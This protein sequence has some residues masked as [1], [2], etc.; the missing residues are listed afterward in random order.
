MDAA[1]IASKS[2]IGCG[3]FGTSTS[4]PTRAYK[5]LET[6]TNEESQAQA[7]LELLELEG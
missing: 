7:I 2:Q 4:L 3:L 6:E 5:T 1:R